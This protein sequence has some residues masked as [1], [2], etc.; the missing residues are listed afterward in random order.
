MS[1]P[2]ALRRSELQ[3]GL[4]DEGN[5]PRLQIPQRVEQAEHAVTPA[6]ELSS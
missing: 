3:P 1:L 5:V 6:G 2:C 4:R